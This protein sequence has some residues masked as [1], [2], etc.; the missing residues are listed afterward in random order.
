MVPPMLQ[1]TILHHF[2]TVQTKQAVYRSRDPHSPQCLLSKSKRPPITA[3]L[4]DK[5]I[6]IAQLVVTNEPPKA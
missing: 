1:K 5:E 4:T 2:G 3:P 6:Q